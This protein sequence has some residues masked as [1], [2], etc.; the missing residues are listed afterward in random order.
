MRGYTSGST[1]HSY[2]VFVTIVSQQ[3]CIKVV[4]STGLVTSLILTSSLLQFVKS[5]GQL[6]HLSWKRNTDTICKKITAGICY[7]SR[8]TFC[9]KRKTN[10]CVFSPLSAL[11]YCCEVLRL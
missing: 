9:G 10:F 1:V 8:K 7:T 5:F 2:T 4:K 6:I 11:N 3:V